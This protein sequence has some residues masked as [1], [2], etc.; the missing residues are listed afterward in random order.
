[1]RVLIIGSTS[2]IGRHI[3]GS[4]SLDHE[5][6]YAG[7]R[8]GDYF[9]D[10]EDMDHSFPDDQKFEAVIH[11]A[12]AF[13]GEAE[14]DFSRAELVNSVGSLAVA[15]LARR[16]RADHLVMLSSVSAFY[17]PG[18]AFYNAYALSKRHGDEL[19]SLYCEK[20]GLPLTILRPTQIYGNEDGYRTHQPL[21][22]HIIDRAA[23]GQDVVL[24]GRNDA[25]R[26]YL[27]VDDLKEVVKRVLTSRPMGIFPVTAHRSWALSEIA[28][29]AFDAFGTPARVMFDPDRGD[30]PDLPTPDSTPFL[31]KIGMTETIEM[32]EGIRRVALARR[33][34]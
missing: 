32:P 23:H 29:F 15:K 30:I 31:E 28:K 24:F 19:V 8:R 2:L 1:M 7:R 11:C 17:A 25:Q 26:N 22:Y 3:G 12:A 6:L 14:D 13:G 9:L 16:V 33:A 21:L 4:L 5:V 18:H 27:H 20:F 10:L 34:P